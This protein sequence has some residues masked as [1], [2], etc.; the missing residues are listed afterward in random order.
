MG[1]RKNPSVS[2]CGL[3]GTGMIKADYNTT[4]MACVPLFLPIIRGKSGFQMRER[5]LSGKNSP[6]RLIG[7]IRLILRHPVAGVG[8]AT[9]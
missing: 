1:S 8:K 3:R 6:I 7:L 5:G 4:N 9:T 2:P